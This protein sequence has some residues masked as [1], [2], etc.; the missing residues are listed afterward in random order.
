MMPQ[1]KEVDLEKM[2]EIV[3][4]DVRAMFSSPTLNVFVLCKRSCGDGE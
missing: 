3:K 1:E 4:H 2:F